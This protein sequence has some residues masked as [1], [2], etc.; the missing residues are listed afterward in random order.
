MSVA[1][2]TISTSPTTSAI[3]TTG[4]R[5][6]VASVSIN[7]TGSALSDSKGNTWTALT[8]RVPSPGYPH[9]RLFYCINPTV[10]AGHTFTGSGG[11]E[12]SVAVIAFDDVV[13]SFNAETGNS[14]ASSPNTYQPGSQTPPANNALFICSLGHAFAT[15][16]INSSFAITDQ[17]INGGGSNQ[18]NGIA[19]KKQTT[20]AAENPT[21]T[22]TGSDAYGGVST[23][24]SF[25]TTSGP[26]VT[27]TTLPDGTQGISYSQTLAVSGGTGS[28]TW[29]VVSG[30]LPTGL[31]LNSSTGVISGTP[32]VPGSYSF[33]VRAT[34]SV[35]A[36]DD[37]ALSITINSTVVL[38]GW[39]N[40]PILPRGNIV[41]WHQYEAGVS[42]DGL[43]NDYS[44]NAK[45]YTTATN[46][47]V[48][49][50][51][52]LNGQPGWY[53]NGSRD[54]MI[55][56]GGSST[57]KH[58]FFLV[59]VD[60]A[61]FS[62]FRGL[63]SEITGTTLLVGDNG[64]TK[65][66]DNSSSITIS[67]RRSDVA[68]AQNNQKAPMSLNAAVL[69]I[70]APAG[71]IFGSLQ[72]GKQTSLARLWKGYWFDD[73]AYNRILS[74]VER[75]RVYEYYAMRYWVWSKDSSD[76]YSTFPF[77]HNRTRSEDF[78]QESYLSEPYSGSPKELVRGNYVGSYSLPFILR[79]QAEIDAAKAF[80]K[81]QGKSSTFVIRDYRYYPFRELK[82]RRTSS[83]R[84]Q[85]SDTSYRF[86]YTFDV[87]EV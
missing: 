58:A 37:Q 17:V 18:G 32:T 61:T 5:F 72:L 87:V 83:I 84:E 36:F 12:Q 77:A 59:S 10:G 35:S 73:I 39:A 66:F 14:V 7:G 9:N 47:S 34:D 60:E 11:A 25:L 16:S 6:I 24:A 31:S 86:N 64:T 21:I 81:Q 62:A 3:D 54:P 63:F 82:V 26:T 76:T 69:E 67:Y 48:L 80:L 51:N 85:G 13:A 56:N 74:D 75:Q 46:K 41:W 45:H 29:S 27:T 65:F 30:S 23:L 28:I 20:A 53:F 71:L 68:F 55:F 19:W 1:A 44:G 40:N 49:T 42:A 8:E 43:A 33:T 57:F 2:H 15:V 52:A 70:Q 50:L 4:A 38:T 22:L 78:D 79:E